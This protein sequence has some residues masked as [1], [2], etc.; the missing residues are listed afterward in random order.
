VA[1]HVDGTQKELLS[2]TN[3]FRAI[4]PNFTVLHYQFGTGNSPYDYIIDNQWSS[5]WS[6]VNG[7]ESWFAHQTYAGE[8]QSAANLTSGRVGNSTGWDQADIANSAWQQYT[9]NQVLA[10]R[11]SRREPA[12]R[13]SAPRRRRNRGKGSTGR[14]HAFAPV[15]GRAGW[16]ESAGSLPA[17]RSGSGHD[18]CEPR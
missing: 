2:Q 6:Y 7:Q 15:P 5:D 8:P 12:R 4:N 9:L 10:S 16:T 13:D 18:R 17:G 3:Q 11:A 1:T 14:R